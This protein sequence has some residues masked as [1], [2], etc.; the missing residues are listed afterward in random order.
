MARKDLLNLLNNT[1]VLCGV[2]Y[3]Y[4]QVVLWLRVS[5]SQLSGY[6]S[7]LN[8]PSMYTQPGHPSVACTFTFCL[9]VGARG[10]GAGGERG[11]A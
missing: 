10:A 7:S 9:S 6:H 11:G 1:A 2:L 8:K 3:M 5:D 4:V